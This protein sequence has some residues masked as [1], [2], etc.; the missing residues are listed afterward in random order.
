MLHDS[1]LVVFIYKYST[2]LSMWKC[3]CRQL[4]ATYVSEMLFSECIEKKDQ[5]LTFKSAH[6]D[7]KFSQ[8]KDNIAEWHSITK[9]LSART[10]C[11]TLGQ[12]MRYCRIIAGLK[13]PSIAQAFLRKYITHRT[14]FRNSRN[15][16][17]CFSMSGPMT[18]IAQWGLLL[19]NETEKQW[20]VLKTQG[21]VH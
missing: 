13:S 3:L 1:T 8:W 16:H 17:N 15:N 7:F 14:C 21:N 4:T 10:S 2:V 19:G 18:C 11:M 12:S 20:A 6:A 9:N 5:F